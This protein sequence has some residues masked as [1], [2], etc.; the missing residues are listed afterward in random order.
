MK[1][2]AIHAD[3]IE[4]KAKKKAFKGAEEGVA[5]GDSERVEECLVVLSAVEKRD[6]SNTEGVLSRYIREIENIASQVNAQNIVLYPYAHLS[7][8][9]SNPKVA[10][11][12]L[13]DAQKRLEG[14]YNVHRAPFGWYKS[15]NISCK[16]H[17]LSELSREFTGEVELKR[18]AKDEPFE[19]LGEVEG[20]GLSAAFLVAKAVKRLFEGAEIGSMGFYYDQAFVDI[21]GVKLKND[22]I[23]KIEKMMAEVVKENLPIIKR[24]L[25][26][27]NDLNQQIA[28]D[29]GDKA[30]VY[31]TDGLAVVPL[32]ENPFVKSLGEIKSFKIINL[33]SAYWK[34]NETN[35]QLSRI[36]CVGFESTEGLDNYLEK[37][38]DAK[39]RSHLKIGKEQGLFVVSDLVGSGLPLIAP[40]GMILFEEV[41]NFLWSLHKGKGYSKVRIPHI[42]KSDL[43]KASGH[44]DKFGDE[45]FHVKGKSESFVMKPMNCPHHIQIFDHFSYSYRDLPVRFFEPTA[46]YRDE[47]AGQ[48]IGLSRVRMITQDDGHIFCRTS[49]IKE[50]V[51]T[52]V[53]IVLA[54]YSKL[55]MANDYWV[56]LSVRGDDQSKYLGSSE[57]WNIAEQSLEEVATANNLPFK[58]VKGEAAFYG[59]K[60]DFMFKDALGR[61]WQLATIQLDFNLPERF[62]LG[63]INEEGTKERPVMIHRA[64]SGSLERFMSVLIEHFGGRYPVWLS[65]VQV[66]IVT[67]T[68]RNKEFAQMVASKLLEVDIRVEVDDRVESMGKKVRDAQLEKVPYIVTVGDK[69]QEQGTLA[70]RRGD[71]NTFGVKVGSFVEDILK[72]VKDRVL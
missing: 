20:K 63:F 5:K 12:L 27:V 21:K 7:S 55:G 49:Q 50:E 53:E 71:E 66:K 42:A 61:E 6:E 54:F 51:K 46:V 22:D 68:D 3:F 30:Q 16:G 59:P 15:F 17:P 2:L 4:F 8:S 45:L 29:I 35:D 43:Y 14:K 47:K 36:I 32:Y 48:L 25:D 31:G 44:W 1:I 58:K 18:E 60:L 28:R 62:N 33:G 37:L 56:S 64:I 34:G 41:T 39:N 26:D 52:I 69:E 72:E 23:D 65:P 9:L 38:E 13:K 19:F 24:S 40:K 57:V 70:V 10:E 11:Q 67:I